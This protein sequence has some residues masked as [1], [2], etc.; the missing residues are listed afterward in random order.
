MQLRGYGFP[1][2]RRKGYLKFVLK[3]LGSENKRDP[4]KKKEMLSILSF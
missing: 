2:I 4:T 1:K 3:T